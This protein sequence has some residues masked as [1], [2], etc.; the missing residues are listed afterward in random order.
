MLHLI[1]HATPAQ[2]IAQLDADTFLSAASY[3]AALYGSGAACLGIDKL[4]SDSEKH[5]FC[6]SRPPG[7]HATKEQA[8][9]FCL[10]NHIAIA[11]C[12]AQQAY[13]IERVA[14]VDFDVHHGNG[15]QDI[16]KGKPG[17]FYI[18]THQSPFIRAR[19]MK[20]KISPTI[21]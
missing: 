7:H 8:M 13:A 11:A 20:V 14:I 16:V 17:L 6:A 15:T 3:E 18:S 19:G 10:F 4:M 12:Y 5:V 1:K 9:G 2:G 21:F